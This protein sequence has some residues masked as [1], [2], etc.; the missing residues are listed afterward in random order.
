MIRRFHWFAVVAAFVVLSGACSP[1]DATPQGAS[2]PE[3]TDTG[4]VVAEIGG[5]PVTSE[6]LD[7]WIRDDLFR[8]ETANKAPAELFTLRSESLDRM[9][10][11]RVLD[12]EAKKQNL[13]PEAL[14]DKEAKAGAPVSDEE[15]NAFYEQNKGRMGNA[16]L[17]Q[18]APRIR[19]F[20]QERQA[21]TAREA[22]IASLRDK[23]GV[24]TK[25]EAPRVKVSTEGMSRG[26]EDAPITIVEFSDYQCPF[27]KR[28]EPV[29][30]EVLKRYPD[31][32]RF[33]YRHFP[34][35]QIHP[36]ARP[37]AEAS[38]CASEQG[39]FWEYHEAVFSGQG[40]EEAD[41]FAYGEA[42]GLDKEKF[43]SCM[44]ERRFKDAVDA[45]YQAGR[46]AGVSGTPAFFINGI[47]LSGAQPVDKFSAVIDQELKSAEKGS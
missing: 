14:L 40:L 3:A 26:P 23:A 17:E 2:A 28:A 42:T 29:V 21:G 10:D 6:Q 30:E 38:M 11:E 46:E 12:A 9:L 47:M 37:A 25:M 39:K 20:L 18:I 4:V 5:Q 22:Y 15:V 36:R 1:P 45:D 27:C 43:K 44:E 19:S 7:A 16:T 34:L 35:D 33:V 24:V 41:L 8:R 13:T 31:Q 32:V